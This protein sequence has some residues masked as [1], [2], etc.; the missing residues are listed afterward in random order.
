[1]NVFIY[2]YQGKLKQ[3]QIDKIMKSFKIATDL[4][5]Y[6]NKITTPAGETINLK[7]FKFREL[8]IG[9]NE[10]VVVMGKVIST[11]VNENFL[12]L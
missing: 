10:N 6:G 3:R 2:F 11:I 9:K 5:E 4:G 12:N 8:N 1:M 7:Y